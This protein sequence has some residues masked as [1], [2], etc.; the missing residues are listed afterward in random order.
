MLIFPVLHQVDFLLLQIMITFFSCDFYL[1]QTCIYIP[2]KPQS[3]PISFLFFFS[4]KSLQRISY[5]NCP[6]AIKVF[7]YTWDP[8]HVGWR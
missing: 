3:S 8:V 5:I 7:P 1:K 4:Q 6:I 2:L